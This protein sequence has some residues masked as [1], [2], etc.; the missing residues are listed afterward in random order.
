MIKLLGPTVKTVEQNTVRIVALEQDFNK[1]SSEIDDK[2]I[3]EVKSN[4]EDII[5]DKIKSRWDTER[6]RSKRARNL[7][8]TNIPEQTGSADEK[9]KKDR[10]DIEK[11]FKDHLKVNESDF[12]IQNTWRIGNAETGKVRVLKVVMDREYMVGTILKATKNLSSISDPNLKDVSIFKDLCLEDRTLRKKLVDEMKI[13]N[14]VLKSQ[15]DPSTGR[16]TTD[17]WV[18]RNDKVILVDKEFK[19]KQGI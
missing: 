11:L 15:I 6:E 8:V 18:I 7:I 4:T 13:K 1:F 2:I 17:R 19:P 12:V 16:P 9:T 14:N 5:E 10:T 3:N